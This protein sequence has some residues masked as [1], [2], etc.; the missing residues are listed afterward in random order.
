MLR[1]LALLMRVR[2][3]KDEHAAIDRH[4]AA[5][6]AHVPGQPRVMR[7]VDVPGA[8]EIAGLESR[9]GGRLAARRRADERHRLGRIT[10]DQRSG[11]A[12]GAA[13]WR[14]AFELLLRDVAAG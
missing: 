9:D 7:R 1:L 13:V 11:R 10:A 14:A 4:L 6:A 12:R 8:D 3:R 2:I 5:L